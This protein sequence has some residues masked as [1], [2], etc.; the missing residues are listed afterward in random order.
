M[1]ALR[2]VVA[3]F[4]ATLNEMV[5]LLVPLWGEI[6]LIHD[7]IFVTFQAQLETAVVTDMLPLPPAIPYAAV[8]GAIE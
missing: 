3:V 7:G 2:P 6:E 1:A 4:G 5:A 8:A